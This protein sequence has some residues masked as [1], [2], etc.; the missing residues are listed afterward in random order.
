MLVSSIS[1]FPHYVFKSQIFLREGRYKRVLCWKG[2][3][4][5]QTT[6]FRHFQK[7]FAD[8]SFILD[9]NGRKFSKRV[10]NTGKRRNC[11]LRAISPFPTVFFRR[12]EMQTRKSQGLYGKGLIQA[13]ADITQLLLLLQ[14]EVISFFSFKT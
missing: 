6:N 14:M 1:S 10:E 11:S 8:D 2:L 12:L 3:T 5:S 4:L 13:H 9:E 7:V